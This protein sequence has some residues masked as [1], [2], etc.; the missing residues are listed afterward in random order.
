MGSAQKATVHC[1]KSI[2]SFNEFET[3]GTPIKCGLPPGCPNP[4]KSTS[5][6]NVANPLHVPSFI[7]FPILNFN[8]SLIGM[9]TSIDSYQKQ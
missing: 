2:K 1:H 5:S 3:C 8:F 6:I 4:I 9:L 7:F